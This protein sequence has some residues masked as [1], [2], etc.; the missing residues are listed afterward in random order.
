MSQPLS[1]Q[2]R[3]MLKELL[4]RAAVPVDGSEPSSPG[5]FAFID[6][7]ESGH[8]MTDA[9]KRRGSDEL[10][11]GQ[12][13]RA[14]AA[15]SPLGYPDGSDR[16]ALRMTPHG[17]PIFLPEGMDSVETWG[18]NV[19]QFG[20]C[21]AKK[22]AEGLSYEESFSSA[23]EEN[24]SYVEWAVKQ[25]QGAKGLLLDLSLY[26]CVRRHQT[27]VTSQ[28]PVIPGTSLTRILK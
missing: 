9:S 6:P 19:I 26:L 24:I 2:E 22:G 23:D 21:M 5:S 25:V 18:R 27:A 12:P 11:E 14:Y 20:R 3:A 7:S 8:A 10:L 13:K 16:Q 4:A 15:L 1:A 28:L 17:Q